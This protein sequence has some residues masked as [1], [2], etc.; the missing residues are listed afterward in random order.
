MK[1]DLVLLHGWAM[2]PSVWAPVLDGLSA[3]FRVHNLALPG[4]GHEPDS[5]AAG[6]PSMQGSDRL[7]RWGENCRARAPEGAV[8]LGWSLG[9]MVALRAALEP[10]AAIA[11][12]IL[13][14]AT[15]RFVREPDW[16]HGIDDDVMHG[17]LRGLR[18]D[19][20]GMLKRFALLQAGGSDDVRQVARTLADCV[21]A[22]G[23]EVLEA[24][25]AVLE[26]ADLRPDLGRVR[27]PVRVIHGSGDRVVPP[28]AGAYV[29]QRVA[30][31]ELV[32]LDTG[33]APFVS[34]P[35]AFNKA[36]LAWT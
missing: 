30:D 15:P 7:A 10:D 27:V 16:A 21:A 12:L 2:D 17:F 5:R 22:V 9:A 1:R 29:A 33:H 25:L 35:E 24:G 13:V 3:R 26:E 34:W 11:G 19:D 8:W 31:G 18:S 23:P 36:V 14:A 4:Y 6:P 32:E 20:R 28:G